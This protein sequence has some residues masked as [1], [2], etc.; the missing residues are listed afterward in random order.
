MSHLVPNQS[1]IIIGV[2]K[3]PVS[4]AGVTTQTLLRG[5]PPLTSFC[6]P[7]RNSKSQFFCTWRFIVRGTFQLSGKIIRFTHCKKKNRTHLILFPRALKVSSL[8]PQSEVDPIENLINIL[9]SFYHKYCF[10]ICQIFKPILFLL[11]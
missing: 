1:Q 6:S 3:T 4:S 8:L 5:V 2:N 11:S 9:L 7:S 10:D